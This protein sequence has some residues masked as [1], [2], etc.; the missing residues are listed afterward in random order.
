MVVLSGSSTVNLN[1]VATSVWSIW[2]QIFDSCSSVMKNGHVSEWAFRF[3]A[4]FDWCALCNILHPQVKTE[5][6]Y[7]GHVFYAY[8]LYCASASAL[9]LEEVGW[10]GVHVA[11][12]MHM[13]EAMVMAFLRF[14]DTTIH[15]SAFFLCGKPSFMQKYWTVL[16]CMCLTSLKRTG[17]KYSTQGVTPGE[18]ACH[19]ER[20]KMH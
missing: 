19:T 16:L 15:N 5:I 10:E 3:D 9:E 4:T 12:G 6:C 20:I 7:E 13:Q 18:K 11:E 1:T 17:K 8:T 2:N 14:L